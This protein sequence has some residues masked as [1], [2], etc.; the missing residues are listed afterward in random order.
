MFLRKISE[1][2]PFV[3][4]DKSIIREFFHPLHETSKT[5]PRNVTFSI[6]LATVKLGKNTLKHLHATS[7]EFYYITKGTG[8]IHLNSRKEVIE[9]NTLIYIPAGTQHTVANTGKD[10]LCILCICQPPY[11]HEDTKVID[12][13]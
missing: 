5:A 9:E 11:T 4:K 3:T 13:G 1:L 10:D 2:K 12:K 6:A 8:I 7:V